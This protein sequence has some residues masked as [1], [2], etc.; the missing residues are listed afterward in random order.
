MLSIKKKSLRAVIPN[1]NKD[2]KGLELGMI[3]IITFNHALTMLIWT[4]GQKREKITSPGPPVRS[5][6]G[7]RDGECLARII[8]IEGGCL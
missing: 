2:W 3:C 7:D 4:F 1:T 8:V 5:G 6:P